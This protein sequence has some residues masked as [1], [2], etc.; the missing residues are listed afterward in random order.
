MPQIM[1]KWTG[2][3]DEGGWHLSSGET[4]YNDPA[5]QLPRYPS[6]SQM[7]SAVESA[8]KELGKIGY[9]LRERPQGLRCPVHARTEE[10]DRRPRDND[11]LRKLKQEIDALVGDAANNT[12]GWDGGHPPWINKGD[13]GFVHDTGFDI[14]PRP[15]DLGY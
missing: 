10:F 2:Y 12:E 8:K 9:V 14:K 11:R 4:P 13:D 15:D 1:G 7:A 3:R 5:K 6:A